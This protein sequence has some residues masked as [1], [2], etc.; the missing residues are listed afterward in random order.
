MKVTVLGSGTSTGVPV[1]GCGCPICLSPDPRNKRFRTSISIELNPADGADAKRTLL[2]DTST[3]LRMQALTFNLKR[4][5]AV[6]Y[7]H[8]HA[9]HVNGIDDLRSFNFIQKSPIAV[10]ATETCGQGLQRMFSYAFSHD[11]NYEGGAPPRLDMRYFQ[12][13][14]PLHLFGATIL[15]LPVKHGR[16]EVVAFRIGAFAYVTDCSEIPEATRELL[17]GLDVLILDGL[18]KRPHRTHFTHEQ[19]VREIELLK[20]KQ[21]YLT[22]ISHEVDHAETN[23]AL[24]AMT[25]TTSVAV[26]LAYD[27]L[28]FEV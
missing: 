21:S 24:R 1:P 22:H 16:M 19:A 5:D 9:D 23:A 3:D 26:E 15:P 27:G 17:H 6:L 28:T 11:P 7:T 2:I 25:A 12:V 14:E 10:Y 13:G 4:V 8:L 18:R 20:P